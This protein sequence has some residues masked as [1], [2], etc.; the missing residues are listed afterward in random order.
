MIIPAES[1]EPAS[2]LKGGRGGGGGALKLS[3][4]CKL[5]VTQGLMAAFQCNGLLWAKGLG[6]WFP[7]R[8]LPDLPS[9]NPGI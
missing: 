2:L 8:P 1:P 4:L 6:V 3:I 5:A 7:Y 9:F